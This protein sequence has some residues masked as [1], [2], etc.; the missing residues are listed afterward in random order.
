ME[1]EDDIEIKIKLQNIIW[2]NS[3]CLWK[4]ALAGPAHVVWGLYFSWLRCHTELVQKET[5][6]RG[7]YFYTD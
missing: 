5:S 4:P 7:A 3:S 2:V 1:H 6:Q